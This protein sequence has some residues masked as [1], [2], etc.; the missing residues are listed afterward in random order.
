MNDQ[1]FT[2]DRC[3]NDFPFRQ[4]KEVMYEQGRQRIRK[5]VC[6][7]CLDEVMKASA[8]VHGIV[9]RDKKAAIHLAQAPADL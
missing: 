6:P 5:Q 7:Q 3:G 1:A 2:C 9:G 8:G 4:M